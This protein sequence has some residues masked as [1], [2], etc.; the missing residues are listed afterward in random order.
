M[1]DSDLAVDLDELRHMATSL[2]RLAATL[3][4]CHVRREDDFGCAALAAASRAF[5]DRSGPPAAARSTTWG[6]P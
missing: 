3:S 5:R 6:R 4:T 1:S 2:D